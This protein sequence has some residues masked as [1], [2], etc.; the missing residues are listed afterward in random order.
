MGWVLCALATVLLA[1]STAARLIDND[2]VVVWDAAVDRRDLDRVVVSLTDG[3]AAFVPKG[4]PATAGGVVRLIELKAP[5]GRPTIAPTPAA[6]PAAFPRPGSKK[7][8]E[9][10]RVIV[11]DYTWTAGKAT[12][13]HFHDK[14]VVVTYLADGALKSTT[15][16]GASTVNDYRYGTTRFNARDRIHTETLVSGTQRAIIVELK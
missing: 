5:T 11:W 6:Y 14:D 1:P 15:P 3:T 16:E 9:N 2:R 10:G 7:I 4:S 8:L 13:M 12:P